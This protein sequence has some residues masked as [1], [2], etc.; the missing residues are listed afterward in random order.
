MAKKSTLLNKFFANRYT[1]L[2]IQILTLIAFLLIIFG[3]WEITTDNKKFAVILRNTNIANLIV[4]SYWWP[5]I[6]VTAIL[7]GRFW[8]SICPM[9]LVTSFF[10]KI[11]FKRKPG[12]FLKSGWVITLFYFIILII[13]IHTFAIHRIPHFMALYMILLFV[14]AAISGIIW[15]KRTFCTHICPI[16]HLLGLYSLLSFKKLRVANPKICE[17]CKSKDCISAANHYKFTNRSCTSELYPAKISDNRDCILCGQCFKSCT[18]NNITI[19][20]RRIGAD[21]FKNLKFG[22]AEILFFVV[23]SGF[24]SYEVISEWKVSKGFLMAIPDWTNTLFGVSGNLKGTI[25]AVTLFVIFPT[26]FFTIFAT[27]KKIVAKESWKESFTQLLFALL[28]IAASMHLLKATLKT[29]SRLPYWKFIPSDPIGVKTANLLMENPELL[30]KNI[31]LE[32]APFIS[33]IALLLSLGGITLSLIITSRK[34]HNNKKSKALT[35]AA[36]LIYGLLFLIMI[37]NWRFL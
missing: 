22:W 32:I 4:W 16:G 13:G 18:N 12:K 17:T 35:I 9:E 3:G 24:V 6:I 23:I 31:L 8:C 29:T 34:K 26:L 19:K 27:L 36:S 1:L 37:L 25:K 2:S 28:P 7:F 11:G 10:G 14:I 21:L 20:N 33:L 15:E 30:N 5:F